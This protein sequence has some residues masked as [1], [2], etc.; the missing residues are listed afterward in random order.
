M[1]NSSLPSDFGTYNHTLTESDI[2]SMSHGWSPTYGSNLNSINVPVCA[3][4][5]TI[6]SGVSVSVKKKPHPRHLHNMRKT[7]GWTWEDAK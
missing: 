3:G 5:L 2:P 7:F 4:Y 1:V 6:A